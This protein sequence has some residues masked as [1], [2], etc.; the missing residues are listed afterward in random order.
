VDLTPR[1]ARGDTKNSYN[2]FESPKQFY[3]AFQDTNP[4]IAGK[5]AWAT[6][7][8]RDAFDSKPSYMGVQTPTPS[9]PEPTPWFNQ[10]S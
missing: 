6:R 4:A 5:N 9:I 10:N 1:A 2:R 7:H 8:Y 3:D